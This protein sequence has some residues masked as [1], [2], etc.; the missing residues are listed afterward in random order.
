LSPSGCPKKIRGRGAEQRLAPHLGFGQ[1]V[2][3]FRSRRGAGAVPDL[4]KKIFVVEGH[5]N[6]LDTGLIFVECK[7]PGLLG[8]LKGPDELKDGVRPVQGHIRAHL[9][10]A[11]IKP[12]TALGVVT[13]GNRWPLLGLNRV[14]QF[15]TVTE[16]AFLTDDPRL[17]A[18]RLWPLAK[19]ALAQPASPLVELL[20]RRALA[21]VLKESTRSLTQKVKDRLPDGAV[22][23]ELGRGAGPCQGDEHPPRHRRGVSA[24][25]PPC[26]R[27]TV[28][29]LVMPA[30][31]GF[32]HG[33]SRVV[34]SAR[35]RSGG[36]R[37]S[38]RGPQTSGRA[39]PN[40]G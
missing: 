21:E 23:E 15:R 12:K 32:P 24:Y 39:G 40:R 16:W 31:L 11:S 20:A 7:R 33:T 25:R 35:R 14:N 9:D 8:G 5:C 22:S 38:R 27:Q 2:F 30:L 19:P 37:G 1:G 13:D 10:R 17:S 6:I 34:T 28:L 29:P 4:P 26:R 36:R 3:P 18:Q